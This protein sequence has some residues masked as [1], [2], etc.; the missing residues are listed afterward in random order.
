MKEKTG[1]KGDC[2]GGGRKGWRQPGLWGELV[3]QGQKDSQNRLALQSLGFNL[4]ATR[5]KGG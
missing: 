5:G 2:I 1:S 3:E 4:G